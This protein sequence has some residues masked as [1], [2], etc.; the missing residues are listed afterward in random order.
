MSGTAVI[1]KN[2]IQNEFRQFVRVA[3]LFAVAEQGAPVMGA[4]LLINVW[5]TMR[6]LQGTARPAA[7]KPVSMP[8]DNDVRLHDDQRRAPVLP[9]SR[10]H[11][12]EESVA[13]LESG[14]ASFDARLPAAAAARGSFKTSS[15]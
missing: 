12:P 7:A 13:R 4:D 8:A 14:I 5:T 6:A 15:R 10:V 1:R 9:S 11:Y 3:T 2:S